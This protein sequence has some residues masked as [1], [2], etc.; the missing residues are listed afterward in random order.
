MMCGL[1]FFALM[2]LDSLVKL[3]ARG[4]GEAKKAT[5]FAMHRE[6]FTAFLQNSRAVCAFVRLYFSNES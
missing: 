4:G 6:D 3:P 5:L 2:V 1:E